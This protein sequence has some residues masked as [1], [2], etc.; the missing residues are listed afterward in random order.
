MTAGALENLLRPYGCVPERAA[1]AAA[2]VARVHES[3]ATDTPF[4]LLIAPAWLGDEA[5]RGLL[6]TLRHD[7]AY[8]RTHHILHCPLHRREAA[9]HMLASPTVSLVTHPIK[10][11]RLI[12]LV[13]KC[14]KQHMAEEMGE[15]P[16]PLRGARVSAATIR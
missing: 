16:L 7:P 11:K 12:E 6:A 10:Q 14:R 2:A 4:D 15:D 9:L 1:S 8:A 13:L 5:S 3:A